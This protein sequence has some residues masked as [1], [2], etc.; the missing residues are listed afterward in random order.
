MLRAL[1][2]GSWWEDTLVSWNV[3]LQLISLALAAGTI[4]IGGLTIWAGKISGDRQELTIA[5]QGVEVE[6]LRKGNLELQRTVE[7]EKKERLAL[8]QAMRPRTIEQAQTSQILRQYAGV[9]AIISVLPDAECED[10]A[11][12]MAKLLVDSGWRIVGK[13][14]QD[15]LIFSSPGV[16][17]HAAPGE[18][19]ELASIELMR[20]LTSRSKIGA[21]GLG[22]RLEN[23]PLPVGTIRI[24]I[25]RNMPEKFAAQGVQ[26]VDS[27]L[28]SLDMFGDQK[29]E[30]RD[31]MAKVFGDF[32]ADLNR[33]SAQMYARL[34][35]EPPASELPPIGG[36]GRLARPWPISEP[37]RATKGVKPAAGK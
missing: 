1:L 29:D 11:D 26:G 31:A 22:N 6:T 23:R 24:V 19:T 34:P 18:R 35:A 13:E 37:V 30:A 12:Q 10:F 36:G 9:N 17:I 25:T 3:A 8:E 28:S 2:L 20:Q 16:G 33:K 5:R 4:L 15:T 7:S 27:F 21:T 32:E 14:V